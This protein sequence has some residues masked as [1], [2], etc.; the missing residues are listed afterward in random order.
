MSN[1]MKAWEIKEITLGMV[2]REVPN[3][4]HNVNL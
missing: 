3:V 1:H 2:L 4:T